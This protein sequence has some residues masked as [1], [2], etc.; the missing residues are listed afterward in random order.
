MR[1]KSAAI[2]RPQSASREVASSKVDFSIVEIPELHQEEMADILGIRVGHR[3]TMD[4]PSYDH[5]D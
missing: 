5:Q 4:D 2:S 3:S 1:P